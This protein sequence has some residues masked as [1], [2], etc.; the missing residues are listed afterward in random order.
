MRLQEQDESQERLVLPVDVLFSDV[1]PAAVADGKSS[2]SI[3]YVK[4][5]VCASAFPVPRV[6]AVFNLALLWLHY[7]VP[8]QELPIKPRAHLNPS[9]RLQTTKWRDV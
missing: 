2:A 6:S 4:F 8:F 5:Y 9:S 1:V 3:V 7:S